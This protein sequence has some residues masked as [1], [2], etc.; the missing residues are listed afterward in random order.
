MP[1]SAV[2]LSVLANLCTL[3]GRLISAAIFYA[4]LYSLTHHLQVH[5]RK[6]CGFE[7]GL[8]WQTMTYY[9]RI[10]Q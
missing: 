7:V 9:R 3:G 6:R 8:S 4:T 5:I 10:L 1:S 2:L